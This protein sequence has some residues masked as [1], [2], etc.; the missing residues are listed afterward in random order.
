MH[1]SLVN[2]VLDEEVDFV[3]FSKNNDELFVE[4]HYKD[5]TL[6]FARPLPNNGRWV[7]GLLKHIGV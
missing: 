7:M 4:L 1:E 2:L 3:R 6:A 5:G